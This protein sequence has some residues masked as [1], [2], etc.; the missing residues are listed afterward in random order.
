MLGISP[1]SRARTSWKA[2]LSILCISV[3]LLGGV[4]SVSHTHTQGEL[5]QDCGLC[6]AA[7]MAVDVTVTVT[8]IATAQVFTRFEAA[9][10]VVR[11]QFTPQFAL[12]SRP[13]PAGLDR[14]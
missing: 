4:A 3:L 2:L 14:S 10:P 6:V 9:S 13:P 1:N 11:P 8:Q 5:H 7:H 12:F